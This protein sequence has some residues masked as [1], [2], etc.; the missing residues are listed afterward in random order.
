SE[1]ADHTRPF[2]D[3]SSRLTR[4]PDLPASLTRTV[5][6]SLT[7]K[8]GP[9]LLASLLSAARLSSASISSSIAT[10]TLE[11]PRLSRPSLPTG[12]KED[13]SDARAGALGVP[14]IAI[15]K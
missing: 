10:G 15:S 11:L 13:D 2:W 1:V 7:I 5:V 4:Q 14:P 9:I 6:P 12:T 8:I 3:P